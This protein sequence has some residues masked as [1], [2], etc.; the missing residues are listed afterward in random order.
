MTIRTRLLW[1][2]TGLVVPLLLL[3][4]YYLW[5]GRQT[6]REQLDESIEQQAE[7]AATAFEQWIDTQRQT[8]ATIAALSNENEGEITAGFLNSIIRT[9]Q[10]WFEVQIIDANGSIIRSQ[11]VR[12]KPLPLV[13]IET[14]GQEIERQRSL[15]ILTEQL[16]DENLRLISLA[17]PSEMGRFVVARIDGSSVSDIFKRLDLPEDHII[18][19]FA[20]NGRLLYRSNVSPEQMEVDVSNTPLLS[21]VTDRRTATIEIDSPY[22]KVRR[23][24]GLAQV[25][26]AN[27]IVAVGVPSNKLYDQ[28][29]RRFTRHLLAGLVIAALAVLAAFVLAQSITKPIRHLTVTA[30]SFGGGDLSRRAKL[31]GGGVVS[32]LGETFNQMADQITK[33]EEELKEIDHLKS[34]FVNSVS[35]ELRTPLTTIKTLVKVLQANKIDQREHAEYLETIAEECDR[36]IEFVQK[37]LD[38]SRIES[39]AYRPRYE[40]TDVGRL[41]SETVESQ[42][43]AAASRGLTLKLQPAADLTVTTDPG[44]LE[45]VILSLIENAMKYTPEGGAIT[46]SAGRTDGGI[47]IDII[48]TGCGIAQHDLDHIFERFYRGRALAYFGDDEI[49][50]T[51]LGLY[52]VRTMVTQLGGTIDVVSPVPG[53]GTGAKF[54]LTLPISPVLSRNTHLA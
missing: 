10:N 34:E 43:R 12:E 37:L 54:T 48:D 14:I 47:V 24:Y 18:A 32:E 39:G 51:G 25:S 3:G 52:L 23:V 29:S 49:S 19:V 36:Q 20:S 44:H 4:F 6:S 17:M 38:L 1:L 22:D 5:L 33:R 27:S 28:A 53:E 16:S 9:R 11:S 26:N 46:L 2:T 30:R 42:Q 40:E 15:V 21:A 7:L 8:L 35:H 13:S 41:L 50:G 45:R 31:S